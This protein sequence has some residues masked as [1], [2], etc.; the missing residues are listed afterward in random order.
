MTTIEKNMIEKE[1]GGNVGVW[2]LLFT[3]F[4]D[5]LNFLL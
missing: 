1:D 3:L 2:I 5:I 4:L